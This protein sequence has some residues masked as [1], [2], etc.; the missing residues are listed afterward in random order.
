MM[1]ILARAFGFLEKRLWP[2]RHARR[3][4]VRLGNECRLI[5]VEF[6]SEPYLVTL[7]DRVTATSTRFETHDGGVCVL[8]ERFPELDVVKPIKVGNNVFLGYGCIILPGVTIGDNVVI[9]AH[10]VVTK[11][12]PANSVFAGVPARFVKTIAE[13]EEGSLASG[14][15]TKL[16]SFGEKEKFYKLKYYGE[17]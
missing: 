1:G 14:D 8:R 13:Y 12:V 17:R 10:S 9:G 11:D 16:L 7:G 4:G 2:I 15:Y 3:L 6:S 5:D